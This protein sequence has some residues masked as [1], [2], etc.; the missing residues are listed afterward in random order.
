MTDK[1]KLELDL[2][3]IDKPHQLKILKDIPLIILIVAMLV[4]WFLLLVEHVNHNV[5]KAQLAGIT[6]KYEELK[7]QMDNTSIQQRKNAAAPPA[8]RPLLR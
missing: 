8:K 4:G 2:E 3:G 1:T 6:A 7:S 5:T